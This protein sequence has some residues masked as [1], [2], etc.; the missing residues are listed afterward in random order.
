MHDSQFTIINSL[1]L[2]RRRFFKWGI[3]HCPLCIFLTACHTQKK[4]VE[5]PVPVKLKGENVIE[6]FDSVL[7]HQFNFN[8][9]TAKAQVQYSNK[10]EESESFDVNL[11]IRKDNAIWLSVTPLL[12]IEVA[13]VLITR[14][15]LQI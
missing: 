6:L 14:D 1:K 9:L 5:V 13:R 12:G 2:R 8:W 11:R 7:A 15:S 3:V 10:G 4:I